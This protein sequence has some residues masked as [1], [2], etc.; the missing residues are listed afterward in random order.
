[1]PLSATSKARVLFTKPSHMLPQAF[2]QSWPSCC[3]N[4]AC[5]DSNCGMFDFTKSRCLAE[6]TAMVREGPWL[7]HRDIC[8]LWG[9]EHKRKGGD[10]RMKGC[11]RCKEVIYCDQM[12]QV[13]FR[14]L[15]HAVYN[16]PMFVCRHSIGVSIGKSVRGG[17]G[18][19]D[20]VS[21]R[22]ADSSHLSARL[23]MFLASHPIT[24]INI[25]LPGVLFVVIAREA[26]HKVLSWVY[27]TVS[28]AAKIG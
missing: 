16:S 17:G 6:G 22:T 3:L 5:A 8:N 20:T 9:C 2:A 18:L 10:V 25:F 15:H 27:A 14:P 19:H 21:S 24:C 23:Q 4:P 7:P 28:R 12:H 1:M 26:I 13:P 11:E